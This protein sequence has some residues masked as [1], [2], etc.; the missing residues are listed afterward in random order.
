[1]LSDIAF[2]VW[3]VQNKEYAFNLA[4]IRRCGVDDSDG[5]DEMNEFGHKFHH[6]MI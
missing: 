5:F 3:K 6:V 4:N 1:M 2:V